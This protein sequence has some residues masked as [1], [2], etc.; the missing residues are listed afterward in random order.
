MQRASCE[1]HDTINCGLFYI[2]LSV[3]SPTIFHQFS[4]FA[5]SCMS[6]SSEVVHSGR[7]CYAEFR[8]LVDQGE[9]LLEGVEV[10]RLRTNLERMGLAEEGRTD[11]FSG[12]Y[13]DSFD[14]RCA[15]LKNSRKRNAIGVPISSPK[16]R[17]P[18]VPGRQA[19]TGNESPTVQ[20][21]GW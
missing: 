5:L 17:S 11:P 12:N 18:T 1:R 21:K 15:R 20:S 9:L 8:A 4:A 6:R 7:G 16:Y 19:C 13:H 3:W 2:E 14:W 10:E